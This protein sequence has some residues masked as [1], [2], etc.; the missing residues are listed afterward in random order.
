LK[1]RPQSEFSNKATSKTALS[2]LLQTVAS[3]GS[4][5]ILTFPAGECSNGLSGKLVKEVA[6]ESFRIYERIVSGQ[7]STMGGTNSTRKARQ[8]SAELILTLVPK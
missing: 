6:K 7:F 8:D 4:K 3:R 1:H 2:N 5:A